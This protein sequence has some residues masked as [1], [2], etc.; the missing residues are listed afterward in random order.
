MEDA[1]ELAMQ[2]YVDLAAEQVAVDAEELDALVAARLGL[3]P[4]DP[5]TEELLDEVD[6]YLMV[7]DSAAVTMLPP[8]IVVHAPAL[9]AGAV[10]THRLSATER[11]E[12]YLAVDGDLAGFRRH[13]DPHVDGTPLDVD[14]DVWWGPPDWLG[15]FAADALLAVQV[16]GDGAVT[17]SVLDAEPIPA[18]G[19]ME[20]VRSAYDTEL[21][22][23]G[24]PVSAEDI[25]LGVRLRDRTAFD[26]PGPPLDELAA[27]AGLERRGDRL[28]HDES[29][30]QRERDA[31]RLFRLMGHTGSPAAA[32]AAMRALPALE[33]P[34]DPAGLRA[35]L[36]LLED[37]DA[38]LAAGDEWV[39][40]DEPAE[41]IAALAGTADRLV[42]VAGQSRRAVIARLIA[43]MAAERGG[44]APDAESH[45][46]AASALAHGSAYVEDRLAWYEADRGDAD[47]ALGRW[48]AAGA[49]DDHPDV[50]MCRRF[51]GA[52]G[53]PEPAR[54]APCWCGS[55]RKFKQCHRGK[56]QAGPLPERVGWL[57]HKAV[58]YVERR[59]G[60]VGQDMQ[61]YAVARMGDD[62]DP[63]V[64]FSDPLTVDALLHEGGW[65][66][67]FL[68][69]R[70]PLLPP[71]EALLGASW[72]LVDRTVYEVLDVDPGVGIGLRDLR[73][74]DRIA[75]TEKSAS[76]MVTPGML[77]CARARPDGAGHPFVGGAIP[78]EPGRAR[79]LHPL[80]D[81]GDGLALLEWEAARNAPMR[82][83]GPDGA[84]LVHC[85]ARVQVGRDAA[86]VLDEMYENSFGDEYGSWL[87]HDYDDRLLATLDLEDGVLTVRA[88][89]EE[90]MDDTL[91]EL[92]AALPACRVLSDERVR[93]DLDPT[94]APPQA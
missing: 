33:H 88:I 19:L 50:A 3:D 40:E 10:L 29:V 59:G 14:D 91:E 2:A 69:E 81:D 42:S 90:R 21:D 64:G 80:L 74:G 4:D 48:L 26:R 20:L 72:L 36:D 43:A 68:D 15:G 70:G 73:T 41:R 83:T 49:P 67:R 54:N 31:H 28:A 24:L 55:G 8:D 5:D 84:E 25:L 47:A 30:W 93:P 7:D 44:R 75:V 52:S 89:T 37:P 46:R 6:E 94:T 27:A 87:R 77:L 11:D 78:V 22:E 9:M 18:P 51:A 85:T 45:L 39:G 32:S 65:F 56:R 38:L 17:V 86:G 63:E 92:A 34:A 16:A 61:R 60:A 35:A 58:A 62:D 76:T 12:G 23:P 57:Y 53:A 82:I 71:D 79:H 1:F 13:P 66:A